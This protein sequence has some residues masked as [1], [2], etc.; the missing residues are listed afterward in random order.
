M[1]QE[2]SFASPGDFGFALD[3]QPAAFL[4][5]YHKF[6]RFVQVLIKLGQLHHD[7]ADRLP[8][9]ICYGDF[10]IVTAHCACHL[11]LNVVVI[12]ALVDPEPVIC[13]VLDSPTGT[14][15]IWAAWAE[16]SRSMLKDASWIVM[17]EPAGE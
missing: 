4:Y 8:V 14:A 12:L 6:P 5:G 3:I 2:N 10:Y 9:R 1:P 17:D 7:R 13:R 15:G 16:I 11:A